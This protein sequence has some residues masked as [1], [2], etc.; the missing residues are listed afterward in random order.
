MI[1]YVVN[2]ARNLRGTKIINSN[3]VYLL[4]NLSIIERNITQLLDELDKKVHFNHF[5]ISRASKLELEVLIG[6]LN[7]NL[8]KRKV[9]EIV[10]VLPGII[11]AMAIAGINLAFMIIIFLAI[12]LS[13]YLFEIV[14]T[15]R[16]ERLILARELLEVYVKEKFKE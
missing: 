4:Y 16:L 10:L 1:R 5:D 15:N 2:V 8:G 12:S 6:M 7:A 14:H 9:T 11:I 3:T 13:L